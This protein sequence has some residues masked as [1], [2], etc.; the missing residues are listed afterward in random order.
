M[1]SATRLSR[2]NKKSSLN[3]CSFNARSLRNKMSEVSQ[4]VF[5]NSIHLLAVSESWLGPT[6]SDNLIS[7]NGFQAPYRKDRNEQGGGVCVYASNLLPCKRRTDLERPDL[8]MV[9]IEVFYNKLSVLVGCCYRPPN[10]TVSFYD[11]LETSLDHASRGNVILV[12]DFNVKHNEWC[13]ED[14]T[15]RPGVKL[16]EL[17]DS[18]NLTQLC[19][20]PTHMNKNSQPISLLD[21]VFTNFPGD[22]CK[23]STLPPVSSS[24]HLPVLIRTALAIGIPKDGQNRVELAKKSWKFKAKDHEGM[25]NA[26][27]PDDWEFLDSPEVN[28][29]NVLWCQW[30]DNFL[31]EVTRFIP[32]RFSN[33]SSKIYP[34]WFHHGLRH[35][36]RTKNRLYQRA[37][38]TRLPEHWHTYCQ[39]RNSCTTAVRAAKLGHIRKQAN[40]LSDSSCSPSLWWKVANNLCGFKKAAGSTG[41]PPLRSSTGE[42][43]SEDKHKAELLNE[44]YIN[45]N[46]SLASGS[47]SAGPTQVQST[48]SL[49]LIAPADV[50]RV[51]LNL[52][53][54]SSAGKD[55]ISYRLIKEAGPGLIHPLTVLF[56]H[57]IVQGQVPDD[58]KTAIVS[59]I[60]KGG[61]KDRTDPS[62]YRPIAL[63]SCVARVLE[64][65]I[66]K[67]LLKYLL[68]KSLLYQHQSGFL[69]SHSTVTQLAFLLHK[70]QMS[71]DR[72]LHVQTA[73][74]DLS[75]AYDRV[76][77]RGLI[78]KLSSI[79]V[80]CESLQWFSSFL[81]NREQCV[82][83]N[84]S[85][86]SWQ[87]TKSGIPQGTVLGPTLFLIYINDLPDLLTEGC[88]IFAD[89]TTIY[90]IGS[91]PTSTCSRL[92]ADLMSASKWAK[93]WGMLFSA[94]KS[95]HLQICTR[96][97]GASNA[98]SCHVKMEE[99]VLHK[100]SNHRH[101]G[102][103]INQQLTWVDHI[104][105]VYVATAKKVGMLNRLRLYLDKGCLC[106]IFKGVIRPRMEYAC[107]LWC[108]GN[109]T[110]LQKL[111]DKFCR[112][113]NVQLTPLETRFRYHTLVLFFKIKSALS[114]S[115][116]LHLLP[117]SFNSATSYDLRKTVYPVPGVFRKTTLSSFLPRAIIWW[118]SLPWSVQKAQSLYIFKHTL[119]EHLHMK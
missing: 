89:D 4:L 70:W 114:P 116:L 88:S 64:K 10:T 52:P 76:S 36:T 82:A 28:D 20:S 6:I 54:K 45:Q 79:G 68:E 83:V 58:W 9:W 15:N 104:N 41:I 25:M 57:S 43:V 19:T 118:N 39:V 107:A 80:S 99:N 105:S 106:R 12:G 33:R 100:A 49:K 75:K 13:S 90:S 3:I 74:L 85:V 59:P 21:L 96:P 23:C 65:L 87:C 66:N 38:R 101:L 78:L 71:L 34:P 31:Q 16:K 27:S 47:F 56:N 115:Y 8:E 17:M 35:L 55:G 22:Y 117:S 1:T 108:G 62:S 67:Q 37:I 42:F 29:I 2:L 40:I 53:T 73:F 7:L 111:Q 60:F 113:H 98:N 93:S 102:L 91:S 110:K 46:T 48:F 50:R 77:M 26:F 109:I 95:A 14:A 5:D 24:D 97:S 18:V 61:G 84:G 86:S 51:V 30:K 32:V 69:P 44:V 119:K 112:R 72:G 63:T 81:T 94:E 11:R 92:S 103:I